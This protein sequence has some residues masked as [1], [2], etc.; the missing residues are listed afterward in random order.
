MS[1]IE[2]SKILSCF[3][4]F[5]PA[6]VVVIGD[7]ILD[8]YTIG[9]IARVSPEAPVTVLEVQEETMRLGGAAN[10]ALNLKALGMDVSLIG[11]V[12]DDI[13]G[14]AFLDQVE[15]EDM[16]SSHIYFEKGRQ[17][18]VKNRLIAS[19]Q[20]IVRVDKEQTHPIF[21][22]TQDKLLEACIT[23][24]TEA[25][26]LVI[27]DYAKGTL[28][29]DLLK[30][31]IQFAKL[32]DIPIIVDPKG[33]DFTKYAGATVIKPNEKEAY[34]A[35]GLE[36]FMPLEQ[37]AKKLLDQTEARAIFITRADKGISVFQK[38][39]LS[40]H[41][42]ALV[43]KVKDVTGAGDTVCATMACCL[44]NGWSFSMAADLANVAASLSVEGVGCVAVTL[45]ELSKRLLEHHFTSKVFEQ[46]HLFALKQ[47]LLDRPFILLALE[48]CP[49]FSAALFEALRMLNAKAIE[50]DEEASSSKGLELVVYLDPDTCKKELLSILNSLEEVDYIIGK[51]ESV[52][53]LCQEIGPH[54]TYTFKEGLLTKISHF[55]EVL[56]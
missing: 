32:R 10:V 25:K 29:H 31:V 16:S 50:D 7:L 17:T 49:A 22:L 45:S 5:E 20:Q 36:L 54:E 42:R 48:G 19:G 37:V 47:V 9:K 55:N 30:K 34:L 12:G 21:Q 13:S 53:S 4:R 3:N 44:A 1:Q 26:A 27:S 8:V 41:S 38:D 43:R 14:R 28:T 11:C 46:S 56:I 39:K 24:L 51:G 2:E 33:L 15:A 23:E 35:S 18:I 6:K 52:K 40:V